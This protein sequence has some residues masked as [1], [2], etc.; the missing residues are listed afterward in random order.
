MR[1]ATP[2]SKALLGYNTQH[3]NLRRRVITT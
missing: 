2:T 1:P 3:K